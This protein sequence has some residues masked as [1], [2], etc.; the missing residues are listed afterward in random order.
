MQNNSLAQIQT[1][2]KNG[3]TSCENII[4]H[5]LGKIKSTEHLNAYVEVYAEK[6][7][8][9][10]RSLDIR[11]KENPNALGK[12]FGCVVSI[13]D[14]IVYKNH[15]VSAGSRILD[16]FESQF[17]ATA[18]ELLL[19]ED[20]IIIGRTNCD[21]FGMGSANTNSYFGPVKNAS[22][23]TRI[24]GGSSG[25]AAVS[26]QADTCL[27]ALGTDT[28]GSVRQPASMCGVMGYKPSYGMVS[29]HGLVAYASSFDQLG[30]LAHHA[31]DLDIVMSV[32]SETDEYDA[33]MFQKDIYSSQNELKKE[34]KDY[35]LAYLGEAIDSDALDVDI[36]KSITSY[37][38]SLKTSGAQ[39]SKVSFPLLEYLV[40]TYYILTTAEAS[41]NLSR[42]DGVR[43]GHRSAE[44]NS[45]E[46][47]YVNSRSEG[48]GDEV[49]KR[50]MLGSFVLSEAYY[51]AYF[52]K[53]QQIRTMIKQQIQD[54]FS[55]Y[56]FIILPTA[57]SVAW[58]IDQKPTDPLEI[59]LS[60]IYTVLANLAG[61]PAISI[62]SGKN[63]EG[64]SF[65][66]QLMANVK[67]DKKLIQFVQNYSLA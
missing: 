51:D 3:S 65:G 63:S 19:K 14:L 34:L 11:I 12:L 6:A 47:M 16:G 15:K 26:V 67:E 38:E 46:E 36:K 10:A 1:A 45:L 32:V 20:A 49:K 9:K 52:T 57:P 24:S 37:L 35:K 66:V 64:L 22:D 23:T 4:R 58:P 56:D 7:L 62:P 13:K 40:P 33:T 18:V 29:R 27:V 59:Y 17:S 50:I 61:I 21:E 53:A 39:V 44:A 2:L 43:Y 54:I 5:Y 8:E 55:Q 41:S 30:L 31:S 28:G 42:Y 48:F 60:D 25:G